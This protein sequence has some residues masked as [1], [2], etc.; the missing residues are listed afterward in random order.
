MPPNPNDPEAL[1]RQHI[2]LQLAQ[3][4][5]RVQSRADMNITAGL[6]V[7]VREFPLKT[8]YAD[9]LLYVDGKAASVIEAKPGGHTLKP[10]G[11][12]RAYKYEEITKRDKVNLDI[13]W[14]KDKT[15]EDSDNLPEPDVL[16]QE[17]A[18]DLAAALAQFTAV[19]AGLKRT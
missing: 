15:L 8:G 18:D 13:F 19:A 5:W 3:S 17:I 2:D 9:Y 11:R 6:G 7:A 10:E 16:A 1:A 12:W 14:L 4:G